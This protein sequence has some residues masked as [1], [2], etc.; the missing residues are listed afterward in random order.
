[1]NNTTRVRLFLDKLDDIFIV[2][3]VVDADALRRVL[4]AGAPHQRVLQLGGQG[5]MDGVAD[6]LHGHTLSQDKSII[7]IWGL[8]RLFGIYPDKRQIFPE[9]L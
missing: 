2:D 7:K 8:S 5:P 9:Y 1:M 6:V 3:G 4:G